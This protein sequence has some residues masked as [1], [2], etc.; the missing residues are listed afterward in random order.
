MGKITRVTPL[1]TSQNEWTAQQLL[2]QWVRYLQEHDHSIGTV[3]KYTQAVA[4]FLAWY[5]REEQ[6]PLI[7][8]SLTP[9]ALIG[10]RNVLQQVQKYRECADKCPPFLVW[11]VDGT[12]LF[13]C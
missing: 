10:Y 7:I 6:S 8:L 9:I 1:K 12:G 11:L 5:E 4:H 2:E 13:G 3:K